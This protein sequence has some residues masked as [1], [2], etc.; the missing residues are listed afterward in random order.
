MNNLKLKTVLEKYILKLN[1]FTFNIKGVKLFQCE[2]LLS[3]SHSCRSHL[4][5]ALIVLCGLKHSS[6]LDHCCHECL[7]CGPFNNNNSSDKE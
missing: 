1:N 4:F 2:C 7:G 6:C 3:S 5:D